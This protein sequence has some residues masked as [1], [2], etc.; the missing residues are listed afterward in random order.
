MYEQRKILLFLNLCTFMINYCYL[1]L[2]QL[3]NWY[4]KYVYRL[5]L[6][7]GVVGRVL[8]HIL[9]YIIWMRI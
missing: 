2:I 7:L 8:L 6:K 4:L 5:A 3:L 9:D 1:L